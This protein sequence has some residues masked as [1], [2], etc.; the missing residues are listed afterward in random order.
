MN[1]NNVYIYYS[2]A[3]D[4]TGK[5][6]VKGLGVKGTTKQPLDKNMEMVI[7]WGAKTKTDLPAFPEG[8]KI[9]NHPNSIR[10]N[11]NKFE[12]INIMAKALNTNG[13]KHVAEAITADKIK[14]AISDNKVSY[15]FIGR[16]KYHQGGKGFWNCPTVA[17]LDNAITDGAHHFQHI[18]AVKNEYRLHVLNGTVIHASKKVQRTEDEFKKAWIEDEFNRQISLWKKNNTGKFDEAQAKEMLRRQADDAVKGGPN[19]LLRSNKMGWRFSIVKKYPKALEIIAIK[20]VKALNLDFGAVDCCID[21]NNNP[22]VFEVNTGPGLEGTS[23][24]KYIDAFEDIIAGKK[25][26]AST[27]PD[28]GTN[29]EHTFMRMQCDSMKAQLDRL[30]SMLDEVTD[31]AELAAIKALGTKL[32]F[33]GQM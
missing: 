20:A 17:Q 14:E 10:I 12:A 22:W 26:V 33:G 8:V 28:S 31:P 25:T 4:V 6:L 29:T 15:P 2:N 3:T 30:S 23:L 13:E 32:I 21:V 24:Q 11:R 27:T 1:K 9:L 19:S 18:I 16:R 7:G 5:K